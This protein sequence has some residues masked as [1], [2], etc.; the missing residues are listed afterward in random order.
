MA[1][2]M[3]LIPSEGFLSL[4]RRLAPYIVG[5]TV[6]EAIQ[7][8]TEF[9]ARKGV[10]SPRLQTELLLAHLLGL[11]RMQLYLNFERVLG[12]AEVDTFREL[13]KRRGQREPLQQIAG[14][15]SFCGLEIGVNR[16]VLIPRP[17]TELLAERGWSFL[18][19]LYSSR[20]EG[21]DSLRENIPVRSNVR[22]Q[23]GSAKSQAL[24]NA[25]VAADRNVRAPG[26]EME[27]GA[28]CVLDL[29]TGSGCLAIALAAHCPAARILATD[30]SAEALA[31]AKENAKR[32][33]VAERIEFVQGDGLSVLHAEAR[34]ELLIANPPYIPTAEIATLQPEVRD[35]EPRLA[36]DGGAD[37][38]DF[39][40]HL[41]AQAGPFLKAGG[42]LMA[43]FGDGQAAGLRALFEQQN[44]IV[45]AI[46]GDYT[47]RPRLL[48]ASY[49]YSID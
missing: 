14:S 22:I 12:P 35:F 15:T 16:H 20:Q 13:I 44:W 24:D 46:E 28:P 23:G 2:L 37:G 26:V 48:I 9:L 49:G 11:P 47:R 5:V 18:N 17:E 29:A 19:G 36:L 27:F 45:E 4:Q 41:A 40:R 1:R 25:G 34:L 43:E 42:K 31:C 8:S 3:V 7:R 33:G 6:L 30:I 39:F 21:A 10:D 32:H 38:L